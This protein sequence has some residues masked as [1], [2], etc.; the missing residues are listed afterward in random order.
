M[1]HAREDYQRFQDPLKKI[2]YDEPVMLLRAQ[3]MFAPATLDFWANLA[4]TGGAEQKI[5]DLIK[6]HANEMRKWQQ[7]HAV[8]IPDL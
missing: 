7:E 1:K 2:P 4:E 3:D 8:K 6:S 5:V